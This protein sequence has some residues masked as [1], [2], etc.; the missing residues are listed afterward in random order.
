L[1]KMVPTK[2]NVITF[3]SLNLFFNMWV[4]H[5]GMLQFIVSEKDVKF[6]SGFSKHLTKGGDKIVF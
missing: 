6:M 2:A 3:D 1:A 4:R 5:H